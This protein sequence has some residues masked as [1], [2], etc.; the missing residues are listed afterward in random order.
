MTEYIFGFGGNIFR[1]CCLWKVHHV[2][3]K[4][5]NGSLLLCG[6]TAV[7]V[8]KCKQ[9]SRITKLNPEQILFACQSKTVDVSSAA[10][11]HIAVI[12]STSGWK[13]GTKIDI[14]ILACV[15]RKQEAVGSDMIIHPWHLG[16][17]FR[18]YMRDQQENARWL[19]HQ[20]LPLIFSFKSN[21]PAKCRRTSLFTYAWLFGSPICK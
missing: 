19:P 15:R 21:S 17:L 3:N 20:F 5:Q 6:R 14:G 18:L 8:T 1:I 4:W 11:T 2:F 10:W 13:I 9:D 12:Y 16:G 7:A